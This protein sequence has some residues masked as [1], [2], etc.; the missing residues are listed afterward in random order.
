MMSPQDPK[1]NQQVT[2]LKA[3]GHPSRLWIV[4]SLMESERSVR[5]MQ[6]G[7]GQDLST[8]SRHLLVLRNAGLINFDKRGK[9]SFYHM[10]CDHLDGLFE[11][12]NALRAFPRTGIPSD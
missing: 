10:N 7:L 2:L 8:V 11:A 3:L 6:Q 5:E 9:Y 12:L 1:L 4:L